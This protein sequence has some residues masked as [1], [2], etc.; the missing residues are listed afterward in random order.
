MRGGTDEGM[1]GKECEGWREVRD[2]ECEG[3]V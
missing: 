1:E 3:R 2:G